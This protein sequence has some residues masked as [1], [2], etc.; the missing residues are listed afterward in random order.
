MQSK[1]DVNY[2]KELANWIEQ[3]LK[4]NII[5]LKYLRILKVHINLFLLLLFVKGGR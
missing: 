2:E 5:P 1:R 3:V 4:S